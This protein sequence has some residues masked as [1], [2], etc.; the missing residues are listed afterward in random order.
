MWA[1]NSPPPLAGTSL[2][3]DRGD[4]VATGTAGG[5]GGEV[6]QG[7]AEHVARRLIQIAHRVTRELRKRLS[8]KKDVAG[9]A[10]A[11]RA[12]GGEER[13]YHLLAALV[14]HTAKPFGQYIM[15]RLRALA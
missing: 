7:G 11:A 9:I 3:E 12:Q 13:I 4:E 6:A 8:T 10:G 14:I 15:E 5:D 2:P 1:H